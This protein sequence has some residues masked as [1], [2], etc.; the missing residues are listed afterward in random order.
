M[1][2][3]NTLK[4]VGSYHFEIKDKDGNV[5]DAW[6]VK[7]LVVTAG[8][9]LITSRLGQ[10]SDA[11]AAY[12]A[13]GTSSTAVAAGQTALQAETSATGLGRALGTFS[14]ATTTTT[15]D[16]FQLTKTFTNSSAGSVAVE[17]VGVFNASS[18]GTMLSRALTGTKTIAVSEQIS[19]TYTLAFA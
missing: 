8:K 15:N 7:N 1:E 3:K 9:G 4:L 2:L 6:D 19:I 18:G 12:I 13:L 14:Q 5:R 16:T 11:V 17:E 10:S